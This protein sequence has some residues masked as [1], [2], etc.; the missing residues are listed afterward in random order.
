MHRP[1]VNVERVSVGI[2]GRVRAGDRTRGTKRG[3]SPVAAILGAA[4]WDGALQAT[5]GES[6]DRAETHQVPCEPKRARPLL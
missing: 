2:A 6:F 1:G 5:P 3:G 4:K